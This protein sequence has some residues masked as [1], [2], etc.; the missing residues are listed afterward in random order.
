MSE[1]ATGSSTLGD[2]LA[3]ADRAG[4]AELAGD[5][6]AVVTGT[7]HDSRAVQPGDLFC[8]VPGAR[9]DGHDALVEIADDGPGMPQEV[10]ERITERFYR[11]D[12]GRSRHRGGSG[13]GLSIADAAVAAHGGTIDVES[14]PGRGTVVLVRIPL[15]T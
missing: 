2:V 3:A 15:M 7:A 13:L 10:A 1:D 12:P 11:A 6:A 5:A 9:R 14:E 4:G 8:C